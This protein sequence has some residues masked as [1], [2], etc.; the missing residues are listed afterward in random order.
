[1]HSTIQLFS[2][3]IRESCDQK[4]S[5]IM[6][7]KSSFLSSKRAQLHKAQ[8]VHLAASYLNIE[9][10]PHSLYIPDLVVLD[11]LGSVPKSTENHF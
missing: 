8:H 4:T 9:F 6:H 3:Q 11:F 5:N 7:W 2:Y 1:M 10:L